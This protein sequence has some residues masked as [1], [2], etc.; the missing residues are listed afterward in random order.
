MPALLATDP[1][2]LPPTTSA[3]DA[4]ASLALLDSFLMA[5]LAP[6]ALLVLTRPLVQPSAASAS[7]VPSPTPTKTDA[8]SAL[9]VLKA[10]METHARLAPMVLSPFPMVLAAAQTAVLALALSTTPLASLTLARSALLD[11]TPTTPAPAK[12]AL[13]ARSLTMTVPPAAFLARVVTSP[14]TT[15][16]NASSAL[17]ELTQQ[18]D[19]PASLALTLAFPSLKGLVSASSVV[20]VTVLSSTLTASPATARSALLVCSRPTVPAKTVL[21]D[22]SR[23]T[24][25]PLSALLATAVMSPTLETPSALFVLLEVTPVRDRLARDAPTLVSPSLMELVNALLAV[26]VTSLSKT[27]PLASPMTARSAL[28]VSTLLTPRARPALMEL[29]PSM[30]VPESAS[31]AVVVVFPSSMPSPTSP[32]RATSALLEP[33]PST[34]PR[35]RSALLVL[36]PLILVPVSALPV[37]LALDLFSTPSPTSLTHA[38][39]ALLVSSQLPVLA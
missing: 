22:P 18:R 13:T 28:P 20:L 7:A 35:A 23:E 31:L 37:L 9:L 16:L 32:T 5:S 8:S 33:M 39:L 24:T 17:L 12:S 27:L 1:V 29:S 11:P 10:L 2:T 6:L 3:T 36:S 21:K 34:A 30:M 14:A 19:R 15:R 25:E 26:L 4:A 38:R